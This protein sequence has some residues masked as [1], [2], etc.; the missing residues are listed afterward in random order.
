MK[1]IK[2]YWPVKPLIS[3]KY[4]FLRLTGLDLLDEPPNNPKRTKSNN[5]SENDN[6]NDGV[7]I[8]NNMNIGKRLN[9]E[10]S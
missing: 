4:I 6:V 1:A 7:N 3:I 10:I 9:N 5:Y 8:G 2:Y